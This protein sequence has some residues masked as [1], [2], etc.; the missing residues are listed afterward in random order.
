MIEDVKELTIESEVFDDARSKFNGVLQKLFQSMMDAKS[1]EGSLTLKV[2][3]EM[4]SK[5]IP[6][7]DESL[8]GEE[9]EIH[10]P[11]F[12]FK[13]SS[14]VAVKNESKG[15]SSPEMELVYDPD[16]MCYVLQ[17][18][19]NT[20]QRSIFDSDFVEAEQDEDSE[21][22]DTTCIDGSSPYLIEKEG[23]IDG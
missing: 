9:R 18:I 19:A 21:E 22:P 11:S 3:V 20:T 8:G 16:L 4:I 6:N 2:D 13:I 12:S 17:Y 23:A 7:T 15:G 1:D 10:V 14:Q 5:S